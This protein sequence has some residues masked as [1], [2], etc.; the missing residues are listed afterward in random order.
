MFVKGHRSLGVEN[1]VYTLLFT[2]KATLRQ[3]RASIY[4]AIPLEAVEALVKFMKVP[5]FKIEHKQIKEELWKE[6]AEKNT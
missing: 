4:N 6:F 5:E 3:L 1:N 2:R